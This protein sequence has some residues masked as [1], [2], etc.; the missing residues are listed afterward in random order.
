MLFYTF[1][2]FF[3]TQANSKESSS[4]HWGYGGEG[5]PTR[6]GEL[7]PDYGLCETGTRQS[8]INI[9]S[10]SISRFT[11][12]EFNYQS[13]PLTV[14][15]NGHTIQV[16]YAEGS[17][18][19]LDESVYKL[20]QFHFHTPSEHY[21]DGKA[22]AMEVH[23][24]HQDDRGKLAVV[25][26]AIEEGESNP[27]L[28]K[29][30]DNLP[31]EGEEKTVETVTVNAEDLLPDNRTY[32]SYSGSLT[33]PPCS[34]EVSWNVMQTPI[35]ASAEQIDRFASIYQVNARP[36]QPLNDRTIELK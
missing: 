16:N 21:I 36:I 7:N 9:E 34:E 18:I 17:Q 15:N 8:P 14:F 19:E 22:A 26:I 2:G 31:L 24:V 35:Q 29:I 6:W 27:V 32:Y 10:V 20:L 5:N 11:P 13:I 4:T 23:F 28:E 1:F 33:T 3:L 25:G 30:W 12:I